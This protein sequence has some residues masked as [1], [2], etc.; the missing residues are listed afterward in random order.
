MLV[1]KKKGP[2][3]FMPKKIHLWAKLGP[4]ATVL[5]TVDE[6][7]K[8]SAVKV[9]PATCVWKSKVC[10]R[11]RGLSFP[12]RAVACVLQALAARL[13]QWLPGQVGGPFIALRGV[14]FI[15]RAGA[16]SL[17]TCRAWCHIPCSSLDHCPGCGA[18]V[19]RP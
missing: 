19:W 18:V 11:S 13:P 7:S 12:E 14:L 3:L 10:A 9:A 6:I 16:W 8:C 4:Q 5:L 15:V 1:P 17:S 2:T